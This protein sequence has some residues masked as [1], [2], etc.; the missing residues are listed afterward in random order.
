MDMN[1]KYIL[2]KKITDGEKRNE[3]NE[4]IDLALE[5]D[6]STAQR[7]GESVGVEK[8]LDP[9]KWYFNT[10]D[11][12]RN[13]AR[14]YSAITLVNTNFFVAFNQVVAIYDVVEKEFKYFF[15]F[16][17]QVVGLLRN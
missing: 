5:I 8:P 9:L 13:H 3:D 15:Y 17:D 16:E 12:V 6:I 4:V 14:I 2:L 11:L 1:S 7:I 10:Y